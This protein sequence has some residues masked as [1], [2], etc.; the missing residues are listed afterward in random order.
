MTCCFDQLIISYVSSVRVLGRQRGFYVIRF[1]A[2]LCLLP[3]GF[4]LLIS[5]GLL[6]VVQ[7]AQHPDGGEADGCSYGTC[8]QNDVIVRFDE[9]NTSPQ[10]SS[11]TKRGQSRD[12]TNYNLINTPNYALLQAFFLPFSVHGKFLHVSIISY[13]P[14]YLKTICQT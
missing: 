11:L 6:A 14:Y 8:G 7:T 2:A 3:C 5:L 9:E 13:C 4:V 1:V 12:V 10:T